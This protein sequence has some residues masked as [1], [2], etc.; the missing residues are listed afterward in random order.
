MRW[1][2]GWVVSLAIV[3]AIGPSAVAKG[4][5]TPAQQCSA[6][7]I[8]AMSKKAASLFACYGK[9]AIA[10]GTVDAGCVAKASG[11]FGVAFAKI[12]AKGGCAVTGDADAVE[13][14]I[15]ADV[16]ALASAAPTEPTTTSTSTSTTTT[17][18]STSTSLPP[19]TGEGSACGA[20]GSGI[21]AR[22]C[23]GTTLACFNN[24]TVIVMPCNSD[25]DCG[26]GMYCA[27][28]G[29]TC[30]TGMGNGCAA[31]CP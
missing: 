19:C 11:K 28:G 29:P 17:S 22:N 30:G 21:C 7:K 15:D 24:S 1:M 16:A 8:K 26:A 5:P 14:E 23:P 2:T 12:D 13:A 31:I 10:G 25:A 18:S 4:K 27:A 9:A 20:C 3:L 6:A